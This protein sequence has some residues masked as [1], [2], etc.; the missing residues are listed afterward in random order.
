MF[1]VGNSV[2]YGIHGVCVILN[3]ETRVVDKKKVEYYVLEPALQPGA[4]YYVPV[5]NEQAVAKLKPILTQ[6]ELNALLASDAVDKEV[7]LDDEN[8]R[9]QH[10]RALIASGDRAAL[11]S[12]IRTLLH[13]REAQRSS[14]RKFHLCDETFLKDAQKLISGEFAWVLGIDPDQV[15]NYIINFKR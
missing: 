15:E 2:V 9:K 7:W 4:R 14:G 11:I 12:M 13:H 8:S 5:H 1:E 3:V 6:Q 10:Y